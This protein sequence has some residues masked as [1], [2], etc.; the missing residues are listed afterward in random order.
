MEMEEAFDDFLGINTEPTSAGALKEATPVNEG[1]SIYEVTYYRDLV[2]LFDEISIEPEDTLVDFGCGLGRVL[3][4][5]NSRHY[6]KTVGVEN[7]TSLYDG[8]IENAGKYQKKFLDQENRMSFYNVEAD[9]YEV[10]DDD[11]YFYFF[12]PF[13]PVVFRKVLQNI[14]ASVKRSPRD[15]NLIIYYPTFAYQREIK[16]SNF[17]ILK[18]MIKMS[19]YKDDPS[20]KVLVYYLSK[21]LV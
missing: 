16:E 11:N 13:S 15:V 8:L 21:Y 1:D 10:S 20:E 12:N 19:G 4:Y 6:C 14:I 5:C 2:T 3:F 9:K 18:K 17:F 7:N